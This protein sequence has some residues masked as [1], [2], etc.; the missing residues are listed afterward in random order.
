[1]IPTKKAEKPVKNQTIMT[2]GSTSEK[3]GTVLSLMT[4]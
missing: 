3:K 2:P 1:M 4:L